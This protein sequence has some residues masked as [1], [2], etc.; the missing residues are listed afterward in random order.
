MIGK[1]LGFLSMARYNMSNSK[2]GVNITLTDKKV[3]QKENAVKNT[4]KSVG[5]P[6]GTLIGKQNSWEND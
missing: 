6:L 4:K 3:A 1:W 5:D 2:D